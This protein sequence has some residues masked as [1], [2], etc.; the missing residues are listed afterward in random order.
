MAH[1]WSLGRRKLKAYEKT[2]FLH[3]IDLFLEYAIVALLGVI[4]GM[5]FASDPPSFSYPLLFRMMFLSTNCPQD[6]KQ[7]K[8]TWPCCCDCKQLELNWTLLT[9]PCLI[10]RMA[11]EYELSGDIKKIGY[12][13]RLSSVSFLVFHSP[14]FMSPIRMEACVQCL[15]Q[16]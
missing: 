11:L 7:S 1:G 16:L 2:L 4:I 9:W 15:N 13:V 8:L 12:F 10:H 5:G 6:Y 14:R 3:S